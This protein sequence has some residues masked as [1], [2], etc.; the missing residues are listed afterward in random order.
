MILYG[1]P[2]SHRNKLCPVMFYMKLIKLFVYLSVK[3]KYSFIG[4]YLHFRKDI[5]SVSLCMHV[6]YLYLCGHKIG[7]LYSILNRVI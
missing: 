7:P 5:L 6:Q 4:N 1:L 3:K 2:K